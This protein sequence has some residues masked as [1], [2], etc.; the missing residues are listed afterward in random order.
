MKCVRMFIISAA[1]R[2]A[3]ATTRSARKRKRLRHAQAKNSASPSGP[4][5]VLHEPAAA[6]CGPAETHCTPGERSSAQRVAAAA[7]VLGQNVRNTAESL[8]VDRQTI[9]HW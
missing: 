3:M 7:L 4:G 2:M 9:G 6:E 5:V 8:G 1:R